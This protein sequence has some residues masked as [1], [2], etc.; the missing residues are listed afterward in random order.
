MLIC[1]ARAHV[2]VYVV[3]AYFIM[4]AENTVSKLSPLTQSKAAKNAL[5]KNVKP[6][7]LEIRF[8]RNRSFQ[9][10]FDS[11]FALAFRLIGWDSA[12]DSALTIIIH[13]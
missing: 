1:S 3:C 12:E 10:M 8:C 11:L 9:M 6:I 7:L 13:S 4:C 5:S 2:V